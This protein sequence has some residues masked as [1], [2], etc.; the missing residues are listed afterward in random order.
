MIAN[1]MLTAIG[2]AMTASNGPTFCWNFCQP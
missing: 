1:P 2:A